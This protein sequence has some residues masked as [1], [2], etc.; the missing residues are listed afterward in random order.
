MAERDYRC[1][2]VVVLL[3]LPSQIG[4][5]EKI[6]R[7]SHCRMVAITFLVTPPNLKRKHFE[8][9]ILGDLD[10]TRI[11]KKFSWSDM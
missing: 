4:K 9:S 6:C 10:I 2:N 8:F 1:Q 3:Q 11:K 5:H 7:S